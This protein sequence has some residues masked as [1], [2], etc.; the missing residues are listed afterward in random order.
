LDISKLDAYPP[1]PE[2]SVH[3]DAS[4]RAGDA[5]GLQSAQTNLGNVQF[6]AGVFVLGFAT[7][8]VLWR[9]KE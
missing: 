6:A 8:A 4:S 5:K 1:T 3:L 2:S 9:V 7:A